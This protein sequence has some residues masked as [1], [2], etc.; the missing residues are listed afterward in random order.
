MVRPSMETLNH[1]VVNIN[2][3]NGDRLFG[4]PSEFEDMRSKNIMETVTIKTIFWMDEQLGDN[5]SRLD[6]VFTTPRWFSLKR[7]SLV[8]DLS[9]L[10]YY[11]TSNE[12][13]EALRNL[14]KTQ[15]PQLS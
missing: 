15:F 2:S 8:I 1:I 7:V 12:L 3:V 5:W 4:I 9:R 14:T 11:S 6:E 10:Y 13:E